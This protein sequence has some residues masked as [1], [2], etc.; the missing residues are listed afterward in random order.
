MRNAIRDYYHGLIDENIGN[1][2]KMW[3]A[4]NKVMDKNE[5]SVKLSSVEV[6]GKCLTRERDVLEALNRHFVSVGS[7]LAKKIVSRPGDDCLHNIKTEQKVMKF[8]AVDSSCILNAIKQLKNGEAA[9]PDKVPTTIVKDVGDLVSKPLSM[10]FNSSLEK[11][12]FPDIWK[13]ARVTPIF[14]SGAKKDVNNY[15]P[16]SVISI[17]SRILER[18]VHDQIFEFLLENNVITKNQSA[19]RKLYSTITSLICSTDHW[20]EN[21]DNKTLNLTIFLDLKKAFDTVDHK[22]LVE[23]LRRY[24]IRDTVGNWFQSYLDQ[25]TQFCATNRQRS[26]AR[27]V[28]CGIPQGSCLGPLLFIIYLNDLENCLKFSQASIY[29]D[30]TNVTIASDDIENWSSRRNRNCSTFLSG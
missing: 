12:V 5:N 13:L 19:F 7:N 24:G 6:D 11:G 9:G 25:R 20:Y 15:R 16:I 10:I 29:A 18:I 4:I 28:T 17:F 21:I 23:K 1:P 2:K 30:D 14:K 3:K 27:E 26:T 22:I 8:K